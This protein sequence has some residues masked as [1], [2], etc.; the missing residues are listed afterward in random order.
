MKI[1]RLAR[2]EHDGYDRECSA[3]RAQYDSLERGAFAWYYWL[4][5]CLSMQHVLPRIYF[6]APHFLPNVLEPPLRSTFAT[7]LDRQQSSHMHSP[8]TEA[9]NGVEGIRLYE[10]TDA[11]YT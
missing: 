7:T 2:S 6:I 10:G 3:V 1:G 8:R 5:G 4:V 9:D 11:C